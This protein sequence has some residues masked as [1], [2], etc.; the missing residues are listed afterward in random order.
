MCQ[1][2]DLGVAKCGENDDWVARALMQ[3]FDALSADVHRHGLL[4]PSA[5]LHLLQYYT[6]ARRVVVKSRKR[7][8]SLRPD[9]SAWTVVY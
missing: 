4:Y 9:V 7:L 8:S 6:R 3:V 1:V 2:D 5:R